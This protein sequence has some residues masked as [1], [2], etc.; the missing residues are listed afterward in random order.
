LF[1]V[2]AVAQRNR[3]YTEESMN[4]SYADVA[5]VLRAG[6]WTS[7]GDIAA[8]VHGTPRAARAVGRTTAT[9][10]DFPNAHRVLRADGSIAAGSGPCANRGIPVREQLEAEGVSFDRRGRADV[11]QKVEWDELARR[12]GRRPRT[13]KHG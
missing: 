13:G 5:R 11:A 2:A 9:S 12:I 3:S 10:D 6:E 1:G 4:T 8:A 7:Y